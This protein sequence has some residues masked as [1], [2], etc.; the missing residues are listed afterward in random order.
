MYCCFAFNETAK[1]F[2][3]SKFAGPVFYKSGSIA[4]LKPLITKTKTKQ[5]IG[6][7]HRIFHVKATVEYS[8]HWAL[9]MGVTGRAACA[10]LGVRGLKLLALWGFSLELGP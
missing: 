6:F 4:L 1:F 5:E 2:D 8:G 9:G 3:K 7:P 10:V